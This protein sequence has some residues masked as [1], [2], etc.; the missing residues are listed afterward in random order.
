LQLVLGIQP[1]AGGVLLIDEFENGLHFSVQKRLWELIFELA[2]TLDI[3]VFATT[4]SWDCIEAFTHAAE[5][6]QDDAVLVK[7]SE[8]IGEKE[9]TIISSVYERDDLMRL[10]QADVEVR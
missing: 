3:Q 7:V 9:N 4:H 5:T 6:K 8:G 10:T 1:A 2:K